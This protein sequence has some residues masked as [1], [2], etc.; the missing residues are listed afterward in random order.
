MSGV[1]KT[2]IKSTE[3]LKTASQ[4]CSHKLKN[5]IW[6]GVT[7]PS[8][9]LIAKVMTSHKKKRKMAIMLWKYF[10]PDQNMNNA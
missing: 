1:G 7:V 2:I 3:M 9:N 8:K 10:E 5:S 4:R 6:R